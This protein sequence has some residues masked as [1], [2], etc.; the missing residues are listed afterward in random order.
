MLL[1]YYKTVHTNKNKI[2]GG[3]TNEKICMDSRRK[4][5]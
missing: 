2:L 3:R 5:S 4:A 1:F